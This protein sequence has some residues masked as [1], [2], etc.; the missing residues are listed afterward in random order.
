MASLCSLGL[1]CAEEPDTPEQAAVRAAFDAFDR[2]IVG[3]DGEIAVSHMT[4]GSIAYYDVLIDYATDGKKEDVLRLSAVDKS[5]IVTMRNRFEL[6]ELDKMTGRQYLVFATNEGWYSG[7][8]EAD[9]WFSIGNISIAGDRASAMVL[10][11]GD[12]TGHFVDLYL[13]DGAWKVDFQ[14]WDTL[15][16]KYLE[17]YAEYEDMTID[18]SMIQMEN[19]YWGSVKKDLL[20]WTP[21]RQWR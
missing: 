2:A 13:E 17:E 1:G 9:D 15:W 4:R 11:L 12:K 10:E 3:A 16:N 14:S 6:R 21:M 20:Y 7:D 19:D 8:E 18:E 5:E